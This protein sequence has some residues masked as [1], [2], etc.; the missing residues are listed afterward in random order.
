MRRHFQILSRS[1]LMFGARLAGAG[2]IF[3]VQAAIARAWGSAMLADYLLL[4]SAVNIAG[5]VM[6]LGFQ[7]IGSYFAV[8]YRATGRKADLVRFVKRAHLHIGLSAALMGVAGWIVLHWITW[9]DAGAA[10]VLV[11][12]LIFAI[13][14]ASVMTNAALLVGLRHQVAGLMADGIARPLVVLAGFAAAL[15]ATSSAPLEVMLWVMAA[16]YALAAALCLA[17]T[18]AA[19]RRVGATQGPSTHEPAR[20]RRFA[21]PW[22]IIAISTEFFFDIDL[23]LLSMLLDKHD[24]AVFGVSARV[25]ALLSFAITIVYGLLLPDMMEADATRD[26]AVFLH[27]MNDANLAAF[28]MS[29]V[30]MLVALAAGPMVLSVVGQDFA[31]GRWLLVILSGILV[32]RAFFGPADLVLSLH[33]RPWATVPAI[34]AGMLV[35]VAGNMVLV[36]LWGIAGAGW[37]ALAATLVWSL[38]KWHKAR[39]TTGLDVSLLA[40]FRAAGVVRP[41]RTGSAAGS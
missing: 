17:M 27:R 34:A 39:V 29:L 21:V 14:L 35:L 33:D 32:V 3:L 23:L 16:G 11:P 1:G 12:G 36:P 10:A 22:V 5:M 20:W 25:F 8:E 2:V 7:T 28:G 19:I 18:A 26:R 31:Q 38:L 6:P 9:I 41:S 37:S 13:S 4:I 40:R 24:L 15:M 30:L